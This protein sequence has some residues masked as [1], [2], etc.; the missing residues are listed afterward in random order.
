PG[1]R[2]A[3]NIAERPPT[4]RAATRGARRRLAAPP[5]GPFGRGRSGG[6]ERRGE[7]GGYGLRAARDVEFAQDVLHVRLDRSHA[8]HQLI[9]DLAIAAPAP[10][11]LEHLAFAWRQSRRHHVRLWRTYLPLQPRRL[12]DAQHDRRQSGRGI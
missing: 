9:G 10:E 7:A 5:S 3:D 2:Y 11:Q 8:D 6:A 1:L 12:Q 4:V